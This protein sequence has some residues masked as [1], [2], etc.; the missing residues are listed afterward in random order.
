MKCNNCNVEVEAGSNFCQVCGTD[1]RVVIPEVKS[2][3][4]SSF[5]FILCAFTIVGSLF[6][7]AR[8]WLYEMVSSFDGN[9]NYIRG[10]VYIL[11][12]LGTLI[13]AIF[14]INKKIMGLYIYTAAQGI[15]LLAV[16]IA[17]FSYR[18]VFEGSNVL[19]TGIS[20]LFLVPS[21]SFLILYWLDTNRK[22]LIL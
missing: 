14:M 9:N 19:A 10:W 4:T 12:N 8:G 2:N 16:L 20:A 1:Q 6:G 3:G 11:T 21:I 15:Y 5:L 13:A 7:V 17:T 18:D 22:H